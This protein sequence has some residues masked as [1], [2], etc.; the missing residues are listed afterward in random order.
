MKYGKNM[1]N[2]KVFKLCDYKWISIK[3]DPKQCPRCKRM[4]W[5]KK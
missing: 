1:I 4:D 3:A 2:K 5:N